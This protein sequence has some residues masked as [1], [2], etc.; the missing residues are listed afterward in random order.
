[1]ARFQRGSLRVE[2]RKNGETWVL[3]Y[4]VTRQSDGHRVEHKLKVGL[5]RDFPTP[6]AVWAEV[7]RQHLQLNEP[8][9]R[10]RVTFDIARLQATSVSDV[11]FAFHV[12]DRAATRRLHL[13]ALAPLAL[14]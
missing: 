11:S 3:R 7:E 1:M 4:F 6:S 8:T 14:G 13:R 2:P 10:A 5:V 12:G 9:F